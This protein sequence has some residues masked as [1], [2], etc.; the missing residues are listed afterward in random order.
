MADHQV[1]M[2]DIER[3]IALLEQDPGEVRI[4]EVLLAID[5][6]EHQLQGTTVFG[7]LMALKQAILDMHTTEIA[8]LLVDLGES[9][10]ALVR[11]SAPGIAT[12][13]EPLATLLTETGQELT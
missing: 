10:M 3:S 1:A 7:Q 5:R 4:E 8:N 13:L 2:T 9:S 12:E 11:E 6:W